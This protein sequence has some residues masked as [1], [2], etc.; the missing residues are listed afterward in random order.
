MDEYNDNCSLLRK[1]FILCCLVAWNI[2]WFIA[3]CIATLWVDHLEDDEEI[4]EFR[5]W[6]K[7]VKQD[8]EEM[9]SVLET[10]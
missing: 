9:E 10:V 5:A 4:S 8:K 7:S 1:I 2:P 3:C 6:R